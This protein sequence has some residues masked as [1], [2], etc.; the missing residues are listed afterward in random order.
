MPRAAGD[1]TA[2][3]GAGT[4]GM[5]GLTRLTLDRGAGALNA[6]FA[7]SSRSADRVIVPISE[8]AADER[9]AGIA[10]YWVHSLSGAGGT[11]FDRI[12]Q[13]MPQVRS[14]GVQAPPSRMHDAAFGASIAALAETYVAAL[15]R[16]QPHGPL[17]LGGW[18]AGAV[19]AL[20]MAQQLRALGREVPLLAAIDG[21]PENSGAALS[22]YDPRYLFSLAANLPR[23]V[24]HDVLTPPGPRLATLARVARRASVIGH[25]A[26]ARS[27]GRELAGARAVAGFMD[28]ERYPPEQR[29]FM[30]RLY[31]ALRHYVPKAYPGAVAVYEAHVGPL[32][33]LPQVGR[34]WRG[35]AA[36]A[37]VVRVNGT[38][39]GILRHAHV[40]HIARDLQARIDT[41]AP[42]AGAAA[43][44]RRSR[45]WAD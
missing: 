5:T 42:R 27:R 20:E 13:Q 17:L 16:F 23:W 3:H 37:V 31:D 34:I 29:A 40:T 9:D 15:V 44:P 22:P 33:H 14:Y 7:R 30:G 24:L 32:L 41:V 12:A 18:S 36:D 2:P 10:F 21:A 38:H 39:L 11:D 26:V 6:L 25:A 43:G 8:P 19:I 28:L 35:L 1:G 45:A 4:R